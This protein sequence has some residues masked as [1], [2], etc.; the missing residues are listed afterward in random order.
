MNDVIINKI[1]TISRCITR[2]T[3]V[4]GDGQQFSNSYIREH[5][6]C[7]NLWRE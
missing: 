7:W 1:T 5:W 3:T 4:Y 2:I 6:K